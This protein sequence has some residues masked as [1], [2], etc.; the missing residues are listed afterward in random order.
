MPVLAVA[1]N[2]DFS[3]AAATAQHLAAAAPRA[4]ALI[5]PGI[6]HMISLEAPE[7]LGRAIVDFLA[8]LPRWG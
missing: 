7:E 6:A 2:L 3:F 8:P 1:G 5:V 4:Q